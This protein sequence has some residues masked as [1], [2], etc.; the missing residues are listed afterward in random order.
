MNLLA[1]DTSASSMSLGLR[2][3]SGDVYRVID[4]GMKHSRDILPNILSIL[5]ESGIALNQL[6]ALTFA[7]GPGSFT[8]LRI[9]VGVVQGIAY[10]LSIPVVPISNLAAIA[11]K[12]GRE[13]GCSQVV[14]ALTAREQEVYMGAYTNCTGSYPELIGE[15]VVADQDNFPGLPPGIWHG[16]GDN[17]S[18]FANLASSNELHFETL[19]EVAQPTPLDLLDMAAHRMSNLDSVDA[20][21]ARPEYVRHQVAS[22]PNK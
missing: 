9:A 2:T 16:A 15:E 5:A 3:A 18:F 1:I 8:G 17:Q 11:R 21:N 6:D 20:L 19:S 7:Q 4:S 10:G 22:P 13:K 14:V 12:L